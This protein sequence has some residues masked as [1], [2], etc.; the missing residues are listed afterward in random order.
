M[1]LF[2]AP[3]ISG[4]F[5]TLEGQEAK[6]CTRVL[7]MKSGDIIHLTDGR[8][9]LYKA[10]LLNGND[11][12]CELRL[13]GM[14]KEYGKR[15]YRLHLAVAPTKNINRFEWFLEKATEIGVDEITPV[16]CRR[17]ER[18]KLNT[19]RLNKVIDSAMKQSLQAYHPQLNPAKAFADFIRDRHEGDKYMAYVEE[20]EHPLLSGM[21]RAPR[22]VT[23]MVGPEGDFHPDEVAAAREQ[24]FTTI[25][26]GNQRL[27]T[28]TAAVAACHTIALLNQ[29]G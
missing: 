2:Y 21:Y 10:A 17:S 28:E 19:G 27:R 20:G 6:H 5:H 29:K 11:H 12:S 25:S 18:G 15:P 9:N 3:H 23:L 13:T 7:R 26:L 16:L 14:E 1:H 8:G 24:G 22:D 4:E